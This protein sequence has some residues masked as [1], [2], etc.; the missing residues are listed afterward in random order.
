MREAHPTK[1]QTNSLSLIRPLRLSA[2]AGDIPIF[3]CGSAALG[4]L[5]LNF[6]SALFKQIQRAVL[7]QQRRHFLKP[8]GGIFRPI[9]E[10]APHRRG[11]AGIAGCSTD[12]VKMQLR[13]DVADGGEVGFRIVED[14][15]NEVGNRRRFIHRRRAQIFRQ[16][17]Q[18]G[19]I[20]FWN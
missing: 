8:W 11:P 9:S 18:V 6:F 12:D 13:Y 19:H 16:I 14:L 3:G 2:F 15:F 20:G 5:W 17:E 1:T 7:H 4:S 10:M